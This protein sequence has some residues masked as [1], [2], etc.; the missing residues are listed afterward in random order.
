MTPKE[1]Q[2]FIEN[3]TDALHYWD[4]G[5]YAAPFQTKTDEGRKLE[6]LGLLGS[7][8]LEILIKGE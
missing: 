5:T 7:P 2:D 4:V 6:Y 1:L 3:L 8:D